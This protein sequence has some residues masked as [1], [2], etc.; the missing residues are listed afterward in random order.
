MKNYILIAL[1]GYAMGMANVIP[2]VSGGTIA[3]IAGIFERLINAIKSFNIKAIK[4]LFS[5]KFKEFVQHTDLKF[6]ISLFI[7]VL[8]A[9]FTLAKLLEYLFEYY[10]IY[11]WAYFFGLI[12][13]SIYFVGKTITKL[14]ISVIVVFLLG[15]AIALSISF[16]KPAV[17]NEN[18]FYIFICGVLG[19]SSMILPGISGSFVLILLGNYELIVIESITQLRFDI[20]IPFA[21]GCGLGLLGFSYLLSWVFKR[22]RNETIAILTG[23]I[24]GSLLIIWPWKHTIYKTDALGELILKAK[25]EPIIIGYDRYFP[26]TLNAE[27]LIAFGFMFIGIL[28][29]WFIEKMATK[30]NKTTEKV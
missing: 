10:S 2:G 9:I 5:F 11:V 16:M 29:I 3:L 17:Q 30:E 22:F 21:L 28:S 15:T 26:E 6:L 24:L 4:L 14:N 23:F 13:A 7:G 8:L 27:V 25:G 19:I 18:L 20:L 1:K 12:L